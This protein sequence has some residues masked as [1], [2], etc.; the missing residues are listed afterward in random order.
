MVAGAVAEAVAEAVQEAVQ[1]AVHDAVQQAIEGGAAAAAA[2]VA[3]AAS[4][5]KWQARALECCRSQRCPEHPAAG[6]LLQAIA[7]LPDFLPAAARSAADHVTFDVV[8]NINTLV[9][10]TGVILFV[11]HLFF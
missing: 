4:G 3:H 5:W 11:R 1:E 10:V 2:R 7:C 6:L 9:A 8:G